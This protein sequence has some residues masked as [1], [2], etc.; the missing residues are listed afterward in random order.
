[1]VAV[2]HQKSKCEDLGLIPGGVGRGAVFLSLAGGEDFPSPLPARKGL[3]STPNISHNTTVA[4]KNIKPEQL[5][6]LL[7]YDF[8]WFFR[9]FCYKQ[10][11]F[12]CLSM[13]LKEKENEFQTV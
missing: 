7:L 11:I 12:F 6:C 8:S 13:T 10:N 4:T 5:D 3:I 2:E 9:F 1:M